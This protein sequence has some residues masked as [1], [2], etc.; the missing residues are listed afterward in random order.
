[1][2][3]PHVSRSECRACKR[4]CSE[5]EALAGVTNEFFAM[6][7]MKDGV[8]SLSELEMA[9]RG[10]KRHVHREHQSRRGAVQ[11]SIRRR[12]ATRAA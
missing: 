8:V 1:M 3:T 5:I 9:I 2:K 6:G 11:P 4:F 7:Y 10:Y 12:S